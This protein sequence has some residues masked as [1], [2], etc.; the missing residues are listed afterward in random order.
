MCERIMNVCCRSLIV[1][2]LS[3]S[4]VFFM[5]THGGAESVRGVTDTSVKIGVIL[6]QTGPIAGD[7]TLPVTEAV[8]NYTHHINDTGGIFGRK[9]KLIVEDDRYSIPTGIAAFKK[10]LFKDKIFALLGPANTGEGKALLPRIEKLKVPNITGV[11]DESMII[12]LRKYIFLPFTPYYDQFGVIYD[13]I[14]NDLKPKE[15][16]IVLVCP[17]VDYGKMGVEYSKRWADS[18]KFDFT[19][20]IVNFGALDATSQVMSIKRRKPTHIVMHHASVGTVALMRDLKKF[21]VNVPVYGTMPTCTEDTVR[22]GGDASKNYV[23]V[24]GFSSWYDDFQGVKDMRKITLKYK[25]G[26]EQP[27]RSKLYTAGWIIATVVYE[28]IRKCGKDLSV[29]NF[30]NALESMRDYDSKGLC[31]PITFTP[32]N[33]QGLH[34]SKFFKA[35][36]QSGRLVPISDW[37]KAPKK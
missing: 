5:W 18:L 9:V 25:P 2:I 36:P 6:D 8:K 13:H 21:G 34:H 33:H 17:D 31:G 4:A 1:C 28:G 27:V 35:D 30:I 37:K 7:V 15:L 22:M 11:L 3:L 19:R 12:P 29:E 20:E 16:N 26:T 24:H 32:T 14:V 23:G 10:L